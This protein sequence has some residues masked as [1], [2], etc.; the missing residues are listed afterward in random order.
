ME[1]FFG[2]GDSDHPIWLLVLRLNV[3]AFLVL[4][5]VLAARAAVR[6]ESRP[7][8]SDLVWVSSLTFVAAALR[9]LAAGNLL[10]QG[11]ISYSRMLLGY[12]GYFATAQ[13][14]SL[15]YTITSRSIEQAI[16]LNRIAGT[17]TV[18]AL[19]FLCRR[20]L[21]SSRTLAVLSALVLAV[22]PLHILLSASADL[23]PFSGLLAVVS[24][25]VVVHAVRLPTGARLSKHLYLLVGALGLALLTQTRMEN[26]LF[27]APPTL[28]V[29]W[30]GRRRPDLYGLT[31]PSLAV[32]CGLVIFYLSSLALA[33][34]PF[35]AHGGL[36]EGI[37]SVRSGILANPFSEMWLLFAAALGC[38]RWGRLAGLSA[39]AL[40]LAALLVPALSTETGFHALRVHANWLPVLSMTVGG[41]LSWFWNRS[42]PW[43]R[44]LTVGGAAALCA[45]PALFHENLSTRYAEMAEARAFRELLGR[46]PPSV[47]CLVVPDD[48][49]SLRS[50]GTTV[51]VFNKY[52]MT[53]QPPRDTP[54]TLMG[55]SVFKTDDPQF[56]KNDCVFFAG[57]PCAL[58]ANEIGGDSACN[59]ILQAH[60][61][62]R[63]AELEASTVSF[64]PC[65]VLVGARRE[66]SCAAPHTT[67]FALWQL[68]PNR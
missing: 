15:I 59:A 64:D 50:S 58:G 45:A 14:Y 1:I 4:C 41:G 12:K 3:L 55:L 20:L 53:P 28:F 31:W 35:H 2:Q 67:R 62:T 51:E 65:S 27:L 52:R 6:K 36:R 56:A 66:T 44:S 22:S 13:V 42:I 17:L 7:D 16:L 9:F 24:W 68:T 40:W 54:L 29:F 46:I 60:H 49:A 10:D 47:S 26:V 48:E 57:L 33:G 23:T 39:L 25:A 37:A 30:Q 5:V 61:A 8:R 38:W 34:S 21:P 11:G 32:L 18:P 19:Y 63:I 43:Q